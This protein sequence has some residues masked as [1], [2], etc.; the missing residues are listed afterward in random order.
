MMASQRAALLLV[1]LVLAACAGDDDT[2]LEASGTIEATDVT[3][4][5]LVTGPIVRLHVREGDRVRRG[6]VLARIDASDLELQREQLLAALDITR[7]QYELMRNGARS[8]DVA[9]AVAAERQ[10][11]SALAQARDDLRRLEASF[12]AGGIAEKSVADA[13]SRVEI[14]RRSHESA[15]LAVTRLRGGAR[16]EDLR[17]GRARERQAEAQLAVLEKKIDDCTV[18]APADGVVTTVAAEEGEFAAAGAP[19]LTISKTSD[20]ELTIY[21][22][23]GDLGRVSVGQKA[24]LAVDAFDDRRFTGHVTYI[25]PIAE[26]TPK[27]VQTK[28]DR[29]KQVFA[30]RIAVPNP[31]GALKAGLSA[32]ARLVESPR[33]TVER[34]RRSEE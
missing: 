14:A 15:Q 12:D 34:E 11:A 28:D 29:V 26:F 1:S 22:P 33:A 17:A 32:D 16:S 31:D 2:R 8:E 25:S 5:P 7:A 24:E 9:Q 30:V 20:V 27:N 21:V 10:A 19:L 23:E 13:R 4:S 3:V 6:D 18:V